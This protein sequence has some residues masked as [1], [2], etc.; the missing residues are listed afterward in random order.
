MFETYRPSGKFGARAIPLWTV[1]L[2]VTL[3]LALVYVILLDV[4]PLIYVSFLLTLVAGWIL[5]L[6]AF[7]ICNFGHVRNS[8][9]AWLVGLSLPAVFLIAKHVIQWNFLQPNL[10]FFSYI[11]QRVDEGW[12]IGRRGQNNQ[13]NGFMVYAVWA[14]EAAI[15][16]FRSPFRAA[17]QAKEP[18]SE[19]LNQWACEQEQIMVLPISDD[20]MI[21]KIKAASTV[22]QLLEIP[23]P[24]TDEATKFAVYNV[25]SI[26]GQEMEDA[27][28]SVFLMDLVVGSN[29]EVEQKMTPLVQSAILTSAQRY[30]LADNASLL[31]EAMDDYRKSVEEEFNKADEGEVETMDG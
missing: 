18:Y 12:M 2:L 20:Q 28:L 14:I 7:Y 26:P 6:V 22:D 9:V 27:Y 21:T 25:N 10:D 24:K 1:G 3:P 5:G 17:A 31:K 30:Q 16:F 19:P 4:I 13:I 29:G 23:I 8:T 15:I 11:D